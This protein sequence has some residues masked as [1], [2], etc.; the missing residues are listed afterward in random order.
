FTVAAPRRG[1]ES[2]R[3]NGSGDVHPGPRAIDVVVDTFRSD[4]SMDGWDGWRRRWDSNPRLRLCR[5]LP[6]PLGY[7]ATGGLTLVAVHPWLARWPD[8]TDG[9]DRRSLWSPPGPA[10]GRTGRD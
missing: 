2:G 5:P 3:E 10:M 8:G 9:T 7:A 6:G 4:G 1:P